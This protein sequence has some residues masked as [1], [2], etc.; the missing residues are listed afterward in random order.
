M[1]RRALAS[2]GPPRRRQWY[3]RDSTVRSKRLRSRRSTR[4]TSLGAGGLRTASAA[5]AAGDV[6]IVRHVTRCV[7]A[8]V[9]TGQDAKTRGRGGAR[10]RRPGFLHRPLTDAVRR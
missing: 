8:G 3:A 6:G 7:A 5:V 1:C 2:L 4:L 10:R 9:Q